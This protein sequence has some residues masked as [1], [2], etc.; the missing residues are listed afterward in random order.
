[1]RFFGYEENSE[2]LIKLREAT[3]D[4][5]LQELDE[6]IDFLENVREEHSKAAEKT[7][8]CHSHFQDW[9][10]EWKKKDSDFIVVTRFN[11]NK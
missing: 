7:E 8:I 6:L 9:S 1:M 5:S 2:K 11:K 10:S 3:F 4:G